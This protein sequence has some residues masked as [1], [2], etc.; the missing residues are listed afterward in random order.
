[1]ES[2][3]TAIDFISQEASPIT[4]DMLFFLFAGL[5]AIALIALLVLKKKK[6]A[7]SVLTSVFIVAYVGV[8]VAVPSSSEK[9]I[10]T[11][12]M[13]NKNVFIEDGYINNNTDEKYQV[14]NI[15]LEKKAY[16]GNDNWYVADQKVKD[17]TDCQ[18]DINP[19][20]NNKISYSTDASF[21]TCK[22]LVGKTA[23]NVKFDLQRY[24]K[25]E[26]QIFDNDGN[27]IVGATVSFDIASALFDNENVPIAVTDLNGKY[28]LY[29]LPGS[30]GTITFDAN[31]K[32]RKYKDVE[33]T[34]KDITLEDV[35]LLQEAKEPKTLTGLIY[36]G[37]EQVGVEGDNTVD[38]RFYSSVEAGNHIAKATPAYGCAWK[39]GGTETRNFDW[40]I[41]KA[42]ANVYTHDFSL[43]QE[44]TSV[45]KDF[46]YNG[47]QTNLDNIHI[48]FDDNNISVNP[49]K[50]SP[51]NFDVS[52]NANANAKTTS[53][54]VIV[55]E[56]KNYKEAKV[57]FNV[58][59]VESAKAEGI[60]SKSKEG[61]TGHDPSD[62]KEG[63]TI[64]LKYV[65]NEGY[66]AFLTAT[67]DKDGKYTFNHLPQLGTQAKVY[68]NEFGYF[69]Q[70]EITLNQDTI[71]SS[72]NLKGPHLDNYS[73]EELAKAADMISSNNVVMKNE[74]ENYAAND[75]VWFSQSNYQQPENAKKGFFDEA[76]PSLCNQDY[77]CNF[78]I[79]NAKIVKEDEYKCQFMYL[80]VIGINH[81]MMANADGSEVGKK[82]GLTFQTVRSLPRDYAFQEDPNAKVMCWNHGF[83]AL[84]NDLSGDNG[85]I[86]SRIA[87]P[88]KNQI[89]RSLKT[90][91]NENKTS[92]DKTGDKLFPLSITEMTKYQNPL[93]NFEWLKNDKEG[94]QYEWFKTRDKN[95]NK[96][97]FD[98]LSDLGQANSGDSMGT[99]LGVAM[100]R[101]LYP[102]SASNPQYFTINS[103]GNTFSYDNSYSQRVGMAPAFAVGTMDGTK[104]ITFNGTNVTFTD[105]NNKEITSDRHTTAST[106]KFRV[107]AKQGTTL[108]S[109]II[110]DVPQQI[111]SEYDITLTNEPTKIVA[112]AKGEAKQS[113]I[114]KGTVNYQ[115]NLGDTTKD[116]VDGGETL[117]FYKQGEDQAFATTVSQNN[118]NYEINFNDD[119]LVGEQIV[120][121]VP[122]KPG[123]SA[124][125]T[126]TAA[127]VAGENTLDVKING[128]DLY[129]IEELSKVGD[130]LNDHENDANLKDTAIYKE[131][132]N[133]IKTD[134]VW[135]S[136]SMGKQPNEIGEGFP[137]VFN[138]SLA[139]Q[140][141]KCFFK[142]TDE[143]NNYLF[144][145][146]LDILHDPL[147]SGK[148]HAGLT[149]QTVHS[150]PYKTVFGGKWWGES[151]LRTLLQRNGDVFNK[152]SACNLTD[153]IVNVDKYSQADRG[154]APNIQTT[155]DK[156]FTI[157]YSEA[158]NTNGVLTNNR[159]WY[160]NSGDN[161]E[162][163][164]YKWYQVHNVDGSKG[165]D[166]ILHMHWAN[167]QVDVGEKSCTWERSVY[168]DNEAYSMLIRVG[169]PNSY[170]YDTSGEGIA[171]CFCLGGK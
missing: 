102:L 111:K 42:N 126:T 130:W 140:D 66:P 41:E 82:A 78:E 148:G 135:Y 158:W 53:G 40:S 67:T 1:M 137:G 25:V 5:L 70:K 141:Y 45:V 52:L 162:G 104:H 170:N 57:R 61:T 80:R 13:N 108:E 106:F 95:E 132:D 14:Q 10:A 2:I 129:T 149:F 15:E 59:V 6:I 167:N 55:D 77:K 121:K 88:L 81:D 143:R 150:V 32:S 73:A 87:T 123:I 31:D 34:E 58:E 113:P 105:E 46:T 85:R 89:V 160:G 49:L 24:T 72:V 168:Y 117:Y 71:E 29:L 120:V 21:E 131:F 139:N 56:G 43:T 138:T 142:G 100:G 98:D 75:E 134:C 99:Q 60:I 144:L 118:G 153:Y 92:Y 11:V 94:S 83:N 122:S 79:N 36:N 12:D 51:Q 37:E 54:T 155:H 163:H 116:I 96:G 119:T 35:S 4:G 125:E 152:L 161:T 17:K 38:M 164:T 109:V 39:I 18:I 154:E 157:S 26:G 30:K 84:R 115:K 86:F 62:I 136:N 65:D 33:I 159:S 146:V 69:G 114:L 171:P 151:N 7:A 48:T 103:Q 64:Y 169:A 44:S 145:R 76:D 3:H 90:S 22:E 27:P 93:Y 133:Y 107:A 28:C 97:Y 156:L 16:K 112:I 8:A 91:V 9:V 127:L 128:L 63:L 166:C 74:F 110:N 147:S 50:G 20:S 101:T 68:C 124:Y 23:V 165:N 47:D 19:N